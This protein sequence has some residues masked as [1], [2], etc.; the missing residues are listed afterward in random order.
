MIKDVLLL[1]SDRFSFDPPVVN[2]V[3]YD[4]PLGDDLLEHLRQRI[5]SAAA[6]W[7]LEGPYR[8]DCWSSLSAEQG[9][10]HI[11]IT[12]TWYPLVSPDGG[13][14]DVWHVQFGQA[15]GCLGVL[16]RRSDDADAVAAVRRLVHDAVTAESDVF[17]HVEWLSEA[18][19]NEQTGVRHKRDVRGEST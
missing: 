17:T 5:D 3:S 7:H 8:D 10:T 16:W 13:E 12:V 11:W 1:R 19:F 18:E 4:C 14:D 15:H 2:G 9:E 6:P